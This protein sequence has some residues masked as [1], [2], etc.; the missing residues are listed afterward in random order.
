M[1]EISIQLA[2]PD[3]LNKEHAQILAALFNQ[4]SKIDY[5]PP[6][7]AYSVKLEDQSYTVHL[8]HGILRR[9]RAHKPGFRYEILDPTVIGKGAQAVVFKSVGTLALTRRANAV[10]AIRKDKQAAIRKAKFSIHRTGEATESAVKSIELTPQKLHAKPLVAAEIE[11]EH[12]FF[13]VM[14]F[15]NGAEL[16]NVLAK[17]ELSVDE[18]LHIA[19][20]AWQALAEYHH[21]G[22]V[23]CDIKPGN[24]MVNPTCSKVIL[25]DLGMAKKQW[26]I[27]N[28]SYGPIGTLG[29][30]SP[31]AAKHTPFSSVN[32][33]STHSDVFSMGVTTAE[34]FGARKRRMMINSREPDKLLK[35]LLHHA[36][37][38]D[39]PIK[40]IFEKIGDKLSED[41]KKMIFDKLEEI[42]TVPA[43]KRPSAQTMAN[44]FAQIQRQRHPEVYLAAEEVQK[45]LA[46]ISHSSRSFFDQLKSESDFSA[47][48]SL[49]SKYITI[50]STSKN[51]LIKTFDIAN[52]EN[53]P[54][55]KRALEIGVID[56]I[57]TNN[58]EEIIKIIGETYE[59]FQ[60][61][62]HQIQD[63]LIRL[64]QL[65]AAFNKNDYLQQEIQHTQQEIIHLFIKKLRNPANLDDIVILSN[66]MESLFDRQKK[67]P[68][69][70][71]LL[72]EYNVAIA[73]LQQNPKSKLSELK[74][75]FIFL[76]MNYVNEK[77]TKKTMS[78]HKHENKLFSRLEDLQD[79]LKIINES[80]DREQLANAII[81]RMDRIEPGLFATSS[82][83]V[84]LQKKAESVLALDSVQKK[85]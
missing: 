26:E 58:K 67:D 32:T 68:S 75:D 15:V 39:L 74:M 81:K 79:L 46:E 43:H 57:A 24:L 60:K 51:L 14:R 36:Q 55:L 47:Q 85:I 66:K 10:I 38:N 16:R 27:D 52:P 56:S 73:T 70:I 28:D 31:E 65:S 12:F 4:H 9:K 30:V 41:H 61:I 22:Y 71:H 8:D 35:L 40:K 48:I 78:H 59:Q 54:E 11:N 17:K 82:L 19:K 77:Y 20:K 64:S 76:I 1:P 3:Q 72:M 37:K 62:A 7:G 29:Y 80:E 18:L 42:R 6:N 13:F 84:A 34:L 33:I 25:I 45:H 63:Q 21:A 23:H 69:I 53:I 83:K 49:L 50:V 2:D 5:F 44:L